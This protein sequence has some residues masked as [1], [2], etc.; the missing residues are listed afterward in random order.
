MGVLAVKKYGRSFLLSLLCVFLAGP[1]LAASLPPG[2]D[3][4]C[5]T[6]R[7]GLAVNLALHAD[8]QRRLQRQWGE[9][10]ALHTFPAAVK[11]GDVAAL[12]DDGSIV[13]QPNEQDIANFGVQFAPQKKGTYVA[14][15]SD[16]PVDPEIGD[17]LTLGDDDTRLIAFPK[18]FKLRF[19][20][21]VYTKMFVQSD[22]NLTFG[23]PDAESTDRDLSRLISGPPRIAPFFADLNP[24]TASGDG[25][26]YVLASKTK[27]V[28]TWLDL[29][30]FGASNHN[31]FQAV[32][33]ANGRITFAFGGLDGR[34]AV[35]GI[36]P[37]N[38]GQVQLVDYAADLPT[39]ALKSGIAERFATQQAVDNLAIAKAFFREFADD[40][41][42]LVVFLDFPQSLGR[43][44]AFEFTLK[45]EVR[46]LGQD[47]LDFSAA[48]G[49]KGRLR[50]FVQM[51]TLSHYPD[52]PEATFLGTNNTLDLLGQESGHRWLAFLHFMDGNG[53][54]S[55]ALLGRDLAH[56]S[57]CHDTLAS[58][59][60][61][62]EIRDDGGGLF[63][64]IDATERYSPLDQYAMGLIG[65]G[66]VPPF[67]FVDPCTNPAAAPEV[68]VSLQGQRVDVSIDQ[69]IAA[70]GPRVPAANKA[71]HS[72]NMAFIVVGP[73]GEAPS[74][75]AIAHV[76][77]IRAAWE[78]YFA[79]ATDG[80]GSV[81]TALK[82]RRGRGHRR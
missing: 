23:A 1:A 5:G 4:W 64:T 19:Y 13:I 27:I 57:F 48:A 3:S 55:Q 46:G 65:P 60:E 8:H 21:K 44:F 2:P 76:D 28:V 39:A 16:A 61:G 42:H 59:M 62:N 37:G 15:P 54:P 35:V 36:A 80:R 17:R 51:G 52:D 68:G 77:R 34:E 14:S 81:H 82:L 41:D 6:T 71:P 26:V 67:F 45:N 75:D 78:P 47:V 69:I 9:E 18:G 31:T 20:K 50:S 24:A 56:W 58:D 11:V 72:F 22:G 53:Q 74:D 40:Y 79:Q 30:E 43:A 33:Y 70:E 49:S 12:I 32:L 66:D 29:P 10:K 73:P 7:A 25:G 63:S 38:G